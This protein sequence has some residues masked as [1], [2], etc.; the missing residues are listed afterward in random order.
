MDRELVEAARKRDRA[1]GVRPGNQAASGS[2]TAPFSAPQRTPA[3]L[4]EW[5]QTFAALEVSAPQPV[6]VGGLPGLVVDITERPDAAK[7]CGGRIEILAAGTWLTKSSKLRLFLLDRGDGES[8]LIDVANRG[9]PTWDSVEAAM[10]IV[11]G[12]QFTR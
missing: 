2:C 3:A 5:I 7:P 12:F 9:Q 8:I 11:Y 10:P 1:S 4:V 6:T